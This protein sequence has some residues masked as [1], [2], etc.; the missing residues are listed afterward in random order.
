[1]KI[2]NILNDA[3]VYV[4]GANWLG[5]AEV[6]LPDIKSKM[7]GYRAFGFAGETDMPVMGHVDKL[8][9]SIKFKVFVKEAASILFNPDRQVQLQLQDQWRGYTRTGTRESGDVEQKR[10]SHRE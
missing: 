3:N 9:G 6:K 8:D 1:M 10:I 2:P 4:D 5:K 7:Q